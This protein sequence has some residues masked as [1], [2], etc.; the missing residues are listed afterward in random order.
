MNKVVRTHGY[1]HHGNLLLEPVA[2]PVGFDHGDLIAL[3]PDHKLTRVI[4]ALKRCP[5][6]GTWLDEEAGKLLRELGVFK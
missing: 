6:T 2:P 3:L 5:H 1:I 4:E